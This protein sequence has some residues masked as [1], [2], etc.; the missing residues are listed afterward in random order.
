MS[1]RT[2]RHVR[3]VLLGLWLAAPAP[4]L[5]QD[6]AAILRR[7][8]AALDGISALRAEFVQR[9]ENPILERTQIGHGTILYRAPERFR[10]D[11][12]Y[13]VGDVVV[14]DGAFVW[15]YLPSS[16]PGQVIRQRAETSGVRNPLTYL[17]DIRSDYDVRWVG[18]ETL[19]GSVTDRLALAPRTGAAEFTAME[20]W[21]ERATGLP[22]QVRTASGDGLVKTYT[23]VKFDRGAR[24]ADSLFAFEPP[25]GV[26]IFDS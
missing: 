2:H 12:R 14:N 18:Q 26:E 24:P 17:R 5:A 4:A 16:Q 7:A 25:R 22:K 1:R 3:T 11:Y 6:A 8:D 21:V 23:F 15:I 13:P 9:S 20:V 19:S 10:I